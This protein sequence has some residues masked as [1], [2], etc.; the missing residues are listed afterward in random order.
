MRRLL[1]LESPPNR[2]TRLTLGPPNSLRPIARPRR[3]GTDT[4]PRL[5][6]LLRT[7]AL[8]L[9]AVLVCVVAPVSI[10]AAPAYP[11]KVGPT[12]P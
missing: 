2:P 11:V 5:R 1:I 8:A 10:D 3:V 6:P 7:G 9:L 12:R 4:R